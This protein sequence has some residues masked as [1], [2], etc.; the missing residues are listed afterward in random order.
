MVW[1]RGQTKNRRP[2]QD[3][4]PIVGARRRWARTAREKLLDAEGFGDVI[5]APAS[6]GSTLV[7]S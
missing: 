6:K 2:R 5:V 4:P 3:H 7:C 1:A